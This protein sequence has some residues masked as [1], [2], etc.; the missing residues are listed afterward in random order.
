MA[1]AAGATVSGAEGAG[2]GGK[3]GGVGVL[4]AELEGPGCIAT[5]RNT[6]NWR[7]AS[8]HPKTRRHPKT[9]GAR[10]CQPT[11]TWFA[12]LA[13][14]TKFSRLPATLPFQFISSK[15]HQ[16]CVKVCRSA[17][18]RNC[19]KQ[20]AFVRAEPASRRTGYRSVS[21]LKC[22]FI[23]HAVWAYKVRESPACAQ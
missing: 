5:Q 6:C 12:A 1:W 17:S 8:H 9:Q 16:Q 7:H 3:G 23:N 10:A 22:V 2:S 19:T 15:P 14:A 13:E 4:Q 11:L 20:P 21:R 18:S